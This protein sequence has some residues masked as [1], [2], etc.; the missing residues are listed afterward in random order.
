MTCAAVAATAAIVR[1]RN[2]DMT[3]TEDSRRSR[4]D[5][6]NREA[7][8]CQIRSCHQPSR[9]RRD[10]GNREAAASHDACLQ[11][12]FIAAVA[13]TAAIVRRYRSKRRIVHSAFAA[14]AATAA[15]VRRW[16]RFDVAPDA[17]AAVAATAAI[18][19]RRASLVLSAASSMRRSRRDCGNREAER[20][21][22]RIRRITQFA[23]V[24]AT[25]AIVRRC[26]WHSHAV[27]QRSAAVA[28]T[29]AILRRHAVVSCRCRSSVA[30]VAATAAILRRVIVRSLRNHRQLAAV[31][32]TAAILRRYAMATHRFKCTA[33]VAA[34]AA[35]LRRPCLARM[36]CRSRPQSP[37]LRQS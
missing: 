22:V 34:T 36:L 11:H 26:I 19:R 12:R 29:A 16:L 3:A 23:A 1:R 10:C 37:R 32:A 15:I 6:G 13:A 14:V 17:A 21:A 28:A 7:G 5:C 2:S 24:A 27:K 33:A 20:S 18:V 35:I 25:A 9:S 8:S 4:R 30:A 31:A